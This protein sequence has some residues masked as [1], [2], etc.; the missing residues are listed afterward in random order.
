MRPRERRESRGLSRRAGR[1]AGRGFTL[2]E[3]LVVV[4]LAA[5]LMG[6]VVMGMGA[7]TNAKL[8]GAATLVSAAIRTAYTRASATAKPMRIVLDLDRSRVWLEEGSNQM[9]VVERDYSMTGGADPATDAE[10]KAAEQTSRILKGPTLPK[11]TFR[12]VKETALEDDQGAKGDLGRPL[13]R[14]IRFRE[15]QIAHQAEPQR[16]GRAYLYVWP[17]GVTEL[18]YI[19][20]AKG[21]APT[22]NDTMTL[23]VHP[24][25]GKVKIV[26][27]AKTLRVSGQTNEEASEREDRGNF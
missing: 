3:L 9:L 10:R 23:F 16:E 19:Q 11:P 26:P 24:L 21:A 8:K 18:A 13:G 1:G 22:D 25:T 6:S 7:V 15:V 27:G 12:A 4:A 20:L 17:G 14:N 2:I 5:I